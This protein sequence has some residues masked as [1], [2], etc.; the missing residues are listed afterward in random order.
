MD[1]EEYESSVESLDTSDIKDAIVEV[2]LKN[3]TALQSIDI[4]NSDIKT[5]FDGAMSVSIKREFK[6]DTNDISIDDIEAVS[7]EDY[8]LEHLQQDSEDKE[9]D[10]LKHKVQELFAK[11]E[12]STNDT[13]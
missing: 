11:Y 3:L 10:G 9:F 2:K 6:R 12:E 5:I 7:L 8:F 13:V 4:Q 1:C